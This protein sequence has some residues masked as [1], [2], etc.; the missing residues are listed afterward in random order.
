ME[1]R[2]ME[3]SQKLFVSAANGSFQFTG[4]G[5][6]IFSI[7][8]R[9]TLDQAPSAEEPFLDSCAWPAFAKTIRVKAGQALAGITI[10]GQ[11]GVKLHVRVNDPAQ[12]LTA[13]PNPYAPDPNLELH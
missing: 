3:L 4:L 10:Q 12:A 9:T 5:A 8:S 6:G 11:P 1:T 2:C 7:C 13:L